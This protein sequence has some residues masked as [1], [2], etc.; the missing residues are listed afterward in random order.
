M[1]SCLTLA[2]KSKAF[3]TNGRSLPE[4]A[5]GTV[6]QAVPYLPQTPE[7]LGEGA[8]QRDPLQTGE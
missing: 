5:E 8:M 7:Q 4:L 3:F 6:V 1:P 2:L